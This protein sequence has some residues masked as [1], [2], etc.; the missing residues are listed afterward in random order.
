MDSIALPAPDPAITLWLC[1]LD[2]AGDEVDALAES[3]SPLELA[4]AD[5]FGTVLLRRR[6][7]SGR[8][9]LRRLLGASL[10]VAPAAVALHRGIRG[11]PQLARE[12]ALDFN[13]SHTDDIALIGIAVGLP[14]G[15]RI[16]VD[17]EREDRA[18]NAD[19]LARKFMTERERAEMAPLDDAARRQRFLRLWTCKEA[20]S[21]A[22]GDALSAPFREIAVALDDGPRLIAGPPPYV[23]GRWRLVGASVPAGLVATIAIWRGA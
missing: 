13:V 1:K 19:G 9:A 4:R 8:T 16:G 18:V 2:R 20:M 17:I 11:R 6:W 5:R 3:L 23:P 14:A 12:F 21:K 7:I 15:A 22:T 10:G